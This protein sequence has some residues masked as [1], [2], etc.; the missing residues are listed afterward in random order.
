MTKRTIFFLACLCVPS[1]SAFAQAPG[2]GH[3]CA[4]LKAACEAAGYVKGGAKEGKG[5][6]KDCMM[7]VMAGHPVNGVTADAADVASC[8]AAHPRERSP[9]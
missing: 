3:P 5:L 9:Q 2:G 7:P 6:L 1:S 4:K 8:K